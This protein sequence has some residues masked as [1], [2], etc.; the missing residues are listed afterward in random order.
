MNPIIIIFSLF[1]FFLGCGILRNWKVKTAQEHSFSILI[2]CRNEEINLPSLFNSLEKLNYPKDKF[3]II[4]VDDASKDNSLQLIRNFCR[5]A[6]NAKFFHLKE[7]DTEYKGKKAAL[8]KA[9]ENAKYEIFIFTDADCI[10][11]PD[12]LKS[13]NKYFSDKTGM[14][15][16]SYFEKN[17]N[18]LRQFLNQ[19][20][21]AI[22]AST[23]GL[24]IPFSAAGGNLAV[25][26]EAFLEVEGYEKI[27]DIE[28]GDDKLLLKLISKTLWQIVYN[29]EIQIHTLNNRIEFFEQQK[30][31]Y[32]KF[33]MSSFLFKIISISI[34]IF[35]IFLP[36][37]LIFFFDWKNL[38]LYLSGIAFLWIS[39][40]IKHKYKF[41]LINILFLILYPYI[42]I[43]FSILGTFGKWRW[44]A[45]D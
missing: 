11:Q 16:G 2:A 9:V 4:I 28:S 27:K 38:I 37:N 30:R 10:I 24:G 18:T 31:K 19:M 13:Y 39:N 7:K 8:K 17:R 34:F 12:W 36:I 15:V 3:E 14:V 20:S 29:P 23:I 40:Q 22:Y 44:K 42:L 6:V 35:Y 43:F 26:K 25:K 21:S 45:T 41:K 1:F 32:G 5:K 33:G